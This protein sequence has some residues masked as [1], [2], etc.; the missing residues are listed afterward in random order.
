MPLEQLL[1]PI[2]LHLCFF[3]LDKRIQLKTLLF[4]LYKNLT[5]NINLSYANRIQIKLPSLKDA[6]NLTALMCI[7]LLDGVQ[8]HDHETSMEASSI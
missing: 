2:S 4:T 1:F 7:F 3:R 8:H 6:L 5:E